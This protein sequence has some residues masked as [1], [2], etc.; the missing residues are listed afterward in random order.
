MPLLCSIYMDD[1]RGF[2]PGTVEVERRPSSEQQ[3]YI[4]GIFHKYK[5]RRM[6]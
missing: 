5:I 3:I 4:S 6:K 2:E 1:S